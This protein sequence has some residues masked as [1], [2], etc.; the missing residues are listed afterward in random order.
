[1]PVKIRYVLHNAYVTGGTIRTVVNQANSLCADHDVEIA[2]VY[3]SRE[4]PSFDIDPRV[5]LVPLTELRSDGTRRTEPPDRSTRLIRKFRRF[6]NPLPHGRDFRYRRFDPGVDAALIRYFRAEK[7]G[8]LIT[9]RPGLNLMSAWCAP[10]RLIRI[11]QDHMNL[12]T[13]RPPL[14]AAIVKAYGRLDAV[15]VLTEHDL[16]DY[17]AALGGR[18]VRV[19]R[20][21]NGIPPYP[22]MPAIPENKVLI[23]AGR[24]TPQKGFDLLLDAFSKVNARH[25]DWQLKI[26][27]Q[28]PLM[29]ELS[30]RI[31]ALGLTGAAH[32]PGITRKLPEELAAA[33]MFVLSSRFEGLPMVLLE[34]MTLGV[35]A[36]AFDCPTGPAEVIRNGHNGLL[37]PPQDTGALADG[38]CELIENPHRRAAMRVAAR[39]SSAEFTMPAVREHW[40]R[41]FTDLA[42]AR[43]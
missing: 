17:R 2:S 13:Y 31:E 28:G 5:R 39:E 20:V 26:F 25:P 21:P 4:K 34:A 27:G 14:R 29:D 30:G 42:A 1:V 36:V 16:A 32:L 7:S 9:T 15:T 43:A 3:R 12:G 22:D 8:V 40:E 35:P 37:I 10:R 33:G 38:I 24:L 41:L 23:A 18:G 11:G 19:E 6:R